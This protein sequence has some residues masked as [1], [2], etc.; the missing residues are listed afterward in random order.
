MLFVFNLSY[1][2]NEPRDPIKFYEM[3]PAHKYN[4]KKYL[5]PKLVN[6]DN[7]GDLISLF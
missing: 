4:A 3:N 1:K 6:M 7:K 2:I 5:I